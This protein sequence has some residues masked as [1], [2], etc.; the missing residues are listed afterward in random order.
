MG[1]GDIP[2]QSEE[3]CLSFLSYCISEGSEL[4]PFK[5]SITLN[6]SLPLAE[7]VRPKESV[8]LQKMTKAFKNNFWLIYLKKSTLHINIIK[9]IAKQSQMSLQNNKY[10]GS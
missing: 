10:H 9:T 3:S 5:S 8:S 1:A 4:K 2:T 7:P 6:V